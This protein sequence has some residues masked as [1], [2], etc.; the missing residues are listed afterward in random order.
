MRK[1]QLK[2]WAVG[3]EAAFAVKRLRSMGCAALVIGDLL[4]TN[5]SLAALAVAFAAPLNVIDYAVNYTNR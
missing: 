5:A 4:Y 1:Y 2:E 3:F